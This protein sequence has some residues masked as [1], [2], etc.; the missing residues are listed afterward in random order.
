MFSNIQLSL[1]TQDLYILSHIEHLLYLLH[2]N[3]QK[4]IPENEF[5]GELCQ[6][7]ESLVMNIDKKFSLQENEVFSVISM[8]CSKEMQQQLLYLSLQVVPLGLLKCVITW[9]AAHLSEDESS[10]RSCVCIQDACKSMHKLLS[11]HVY[12]EEVELWPLFGECFTL[13]EQERIIGSML[14]RTGA[15]IL[16]DMIPWLMASLSPDEQQ[17]VMSLWHNATRNTMFDEWLGEWWEGHKIAKETEKTT[18]PSWSADPLEIISTFSR[19]DKVRA[20]K[21][22]GNCSECSGLLS[23]NSDKQC[24]EAADLMGRTN[25]PDQKFQVI[26]ILGN[27]RTR[28]YESRRSRGCHKKGVL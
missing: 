22:D 21:G 11:D 20:C 8:N 10:A 4:R 24:N 12:R 14:G 26:G 15:E 2:G 6:K 3:N 23:K 9:F 13:K 18:V 25:E 16:E 5:V 17:T 19:N 1:P 27:A 7:L 28:Y